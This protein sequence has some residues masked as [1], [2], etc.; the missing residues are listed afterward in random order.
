[1]YRISI[2]RLTYLEHHYNLFHHHTF[3]RNDNTHIKP[4]NDQTMNTKSNFVDV[5]YFLHDKD[6]LLYVEALH[7]LFQ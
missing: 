3:R 1:M 5:Y 2:D 6:E 7:Y 4:L